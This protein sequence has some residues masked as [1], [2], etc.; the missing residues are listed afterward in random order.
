MKKT[1][2]IIIGLIVFTGPLLVMPKQLKYLKILND[3]NSVGAIVYARP[4]QCYSKRNFFDFK[5]MD[6]V[7]SKHVSPQFCLSHKVGDSVMFYHQDSTPEIFLFPGTEQKVYW[8]IASCVGL[9]MLGLITLIKRDE[10]SKR[11]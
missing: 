2:V 3:H 9:S 8:D 1:V 7:F 11:F 4:K 6:H 5:Y 10:I